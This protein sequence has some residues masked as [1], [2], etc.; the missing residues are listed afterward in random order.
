MQA[1]SKFDF[2]VQLAEAFGFD[3]DLIIP[4]RA[5]GIARDARRSLNLTLK[6]EKLLSVLGHPLPSI[7]QGIER[8]HQRW[9]EG[10]PQVLHSY[11]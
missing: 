9:L 1:I 7:Q 5:A 3:P 8:L 6:N 10:Y 2:G 11:Y 4:T